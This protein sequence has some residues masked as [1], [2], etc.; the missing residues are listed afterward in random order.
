MKHENN[1][2][3]NVLLHLENIMLNGGMCQNGKKQLF[4]YVFDPHTGQYKEDTIQKVM[5]HK[6][7]VSEE[8]KQSSYFSLFKKP[9]T[10]IIL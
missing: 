5:S 3:K 4:Y 6:M 2:G 8:I 1:K 9:L 10:F 7:E